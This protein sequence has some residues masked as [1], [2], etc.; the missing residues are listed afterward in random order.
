MTTT[1]T[2]DNFHVTI[3]DLT[4]PAW[5]QAI[6]KAIEARTGKKVSS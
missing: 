2:F 4:P 1:I 5:V 3:T 6:K